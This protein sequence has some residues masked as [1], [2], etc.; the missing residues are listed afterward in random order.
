[1]AKRLHA[2]TP[3][4]PLDS[5]LLSSVLRPNPEEVETESASIS[6]SVA[7]QKTVIRSRRH[8]RAGSADIR[9]PGETPPVELRVEK[10]NAVLR[11]KVSKREKRDFEAMVARLSGVLDATV[12]P[13]NVLRSMLGVLTQIESHVLDHADAF[14]PYHR[15]PNDDA[16]SYA[17][18]EHRLLRLFDACIRAAK[19]IG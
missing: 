3:Y 19:P 7:V 18:F 12:K 14:G 13:S 4:S 10:L 9:L 8:R 15:P 1:M 5:R 11:L 16:V 17:D 6:K 2:E